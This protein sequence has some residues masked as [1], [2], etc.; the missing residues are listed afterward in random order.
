MAKARVDFVA[1]DHELESAHE[2]ATEAL[3]EHRWH[4]TLDE[5]NPKRITLREYGRR[6]GRN[7]RTIRRMANGYEAWL[8]RP[9]AA[10]PG[11]PVTLTEYIEQ[12]NLGA[13][14][15]EATEA[16]AAATGTTFSHVA[17]RKRDEVRDVV[18]TARDR[19]ERKGTT[20]S[21]EIPAVAEWR[22]KS[23][24]AR[25]KEAQERSE[26]RFVLVELEG[27]IGAAVR[28]LREGLLLAKEIDFDDEQIEMIADTLAKLRAIVALI[29]LKITGESGVN[30]DDEFA[31]VMG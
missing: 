31:R 8:R 7:D 27:H 28:R 21:D 1:R 12:A 6:V 14:K 17:K 10:P 26:S 2:R 11:S 29:D 5:S 30:W 19:A 15:A 25:Q 13:E 18:A 4:W 9:A 3:A 22:E 24:Q 16:V 20:V 23:R